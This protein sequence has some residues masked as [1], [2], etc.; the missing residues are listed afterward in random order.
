M[1]QRLGILSV[2][3]DSSESQYSMTAVG[4]PGRLSKLSA[5]HFEAGMAIRNGMR[6]LSLIEVL[7]PEII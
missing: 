4:E 3:K 1:L 7:V 5:L 2:S 6:A